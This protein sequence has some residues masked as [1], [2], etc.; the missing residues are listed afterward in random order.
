MVVAICYYIMLSQ[1]FLGKIINRSIQDDFQTGQLRR[2]L[3]PAGFLPAAG[4]YCFTCDDVH[5][6]TV[7]PAG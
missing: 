3:V 6:V 5:A 1:N 2:G 4:R 7:A